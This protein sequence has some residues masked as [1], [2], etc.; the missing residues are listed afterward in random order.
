MS[1]VVSLKDWKQQ[2]PDR[3]IVSL[4]YGRTVMN[5]TSEDRR[6][7]YVSHVN[8]WPHT[9]KEFDEILEAFLEK[10][11]TVKLVKIIEHPEEDA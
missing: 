10:H 8:K 4:L 11:P 1:N 2:R 6:T 7:T 5:I 9:Q 3:I